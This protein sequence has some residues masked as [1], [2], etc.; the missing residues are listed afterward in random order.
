MF[1]A[2]VGLPLLLYLRTVAPTVYGLDSA[3]LTAGAYL[4]GIVHAPGSPTY[5]LLG[6]VFTW[7]PFGDVGY[8][9][10]LLSACSAALAAGFVYAILFR[11]TRA[12]L[13][14][15]AGCLYLATT[16]YFWV[17]AVA[18]ELYALH[19]AFIAALVWL[20]LI[21][22]ETRRAVILALL[23]L[24]YGLGLGNHLSLSV[25]APGFA[26]MVIA[27]MPEIW[28]RPRLLITGA[29]SLIAGWSVYLYLP[30][31]AAAGVAMNYARDFGVDVTTWNGFWWM[32]TGSMFGGEMLGVSPAALPAELL[33]YFYRLWSNFLGLGCMLGF[34]GLAADFGRR[35]DIHLPLAL[36][37]L[38]HLIFA[39]TYSVADKEFM[40]LPTFLVWGIWAVLGTGEAV[41]YAREHGGEIFSVSAAMLLAVMTLSNVMVN[42]TRVDVSRDW[43]A[44][45]RG[46]VLLGWLPPQ[47]LYVATWAD[48]ALIDYLQ[49]VEAERKD[50]DMLNVFLVRGTRRRERVEEQLR[51]GGAVYAS[52][53]FSLGRGFVFEHEETCDCYQVKRS[54]EPACM[55]AP[56]P[57]RQSRGPRWR[58]EPSGFDGNT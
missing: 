35:R 7:L 32:V 19:A 52:A 53:P 31:R 50:V 20:A 15:L 1:A 55:A 37:F 5:L 26:V 13:Q 46:E 29:L 17:T 47:T 49:F 43:T 34:V 38:G 14:S 39:V 21:W 42:F 16:Y 54:E 25:L 23:C 28:R 11:L 22:Q 3:E 44:R 40:L 57:F 10:N 6:H 36:M 58:G 12:H 9:V 48:A 27:G 24:L 18:A 8:R 30:I 2:A 4:L 45:N 41:R 51:R 33:H 56:E